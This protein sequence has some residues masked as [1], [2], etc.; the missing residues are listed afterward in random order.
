[1]TV[2]Q[3]LIAATEANATLTADWKAKC[4]A[5]AMLTAENTGLKTAL[6][7]VKASVVAL[8][9]EHAKALTVAETAFKA[10]QTAHITTK[11][12]LE[13]AKK[14]LANPAFAAAAVTGSKVAVAEGG[15]EAQDTAK[16]TKENAEAEYKKIVDPKARA[17]F[18]D[19]YA[20]E[21]GLKK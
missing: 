5:V 3:E 10:E 19:K 14:A 13:T 9:D 12:E 1:M 4:E 2:A 21:L 11:T 20:V 8:K 6:E 7:T 18:R 17:D 15:A 16:I